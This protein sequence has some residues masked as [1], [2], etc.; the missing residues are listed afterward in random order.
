MVWVLLRRVTTRNG[1][2]VVGQAVCNM[3]LVERVFLIRARGSNDRLLAWLAIVTM[4]FVRA[5]AIA[6]GIRWAH[7]CCLCVI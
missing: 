2:L 4:P 1:V 5:I 7:N 6:K 3:Q